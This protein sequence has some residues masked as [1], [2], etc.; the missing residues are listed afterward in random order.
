MIDGS[1]FLVG[2]VV[3]KLCALE[4]EKQFAVVTAGAIDSAARPVV[5]TTATLWELSAAEDPI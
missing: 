2:A 3:P 4:L 1:S 5:R